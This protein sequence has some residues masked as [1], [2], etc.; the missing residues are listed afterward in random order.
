M[1]RIPATPANLQKLATDLQAAAEKTRLLILHLLMEGVQTNSEIVQALNLA[2]NLVSHHLRTLR[3]AGLIQRERGAVDGRWVY[4]SINREAL[5]ELTRAFGAF[6]D[7][8]RQ[9]SRRPSCGP[10]AAL[11]E[12]TSDG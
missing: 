8:Q 6:F 1:R 7:P 2:P 9:K 5:E 3:A 12:T 10:Q 4:Y 11:A